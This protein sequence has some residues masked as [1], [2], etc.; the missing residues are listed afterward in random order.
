M[1]EN[2]IVF[3]VSKTRIAV[4]CELPIRKQSLKRNGKCCEVSSNYNLSSVDTL[5]GLILVSTYIK[6][7]GSYWN[8]CYLNFYENFSKSIYLHINVYINIHVSI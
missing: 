4:R 2:F 3:A 1:W 6:R 7:L 8:S 5:H